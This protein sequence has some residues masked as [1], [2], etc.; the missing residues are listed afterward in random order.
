MMSSGVILSCDSQGCFSRLILKY[1][2]RLKQ[3]IPK[4]LIPKLSSGE[5]AEIQSLV[6]VSVKPFNAWRHWIEKNPQAANVFL[7]AYKLAMYGVMKSGYAVDDA[8]LTALEVKLKKVPDVL[9]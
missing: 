8:K 6:A 5:T 7:E 3:L 4:Q 9:K 1:L 2:T